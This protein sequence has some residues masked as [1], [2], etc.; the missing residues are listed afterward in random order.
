[1]QAELRDYSDVRT[2]DADALLQRR[3]EMAGKLFRRIEHAYGIDLADASLD[4][5][6]RLIMLA[7]GEDRKRD[8]GMVQQ[9]LAAY[10]KR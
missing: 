8:A 2:A 6:C 4:Q 5:A 7:T 1:M 10:L 9:D 3:Q